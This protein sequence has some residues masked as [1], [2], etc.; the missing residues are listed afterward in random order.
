MRERPE[1]LLAHE[2]RPAPRLARPSKRARDKGSLSGADQVAGGVDLVPHV[3]EQHA[4]RLAV[5]D[6]RDDALAVRL[7][8]VLDDLEP[9]VDE[10]DGLVAEVEEVGVEERQ[11]VVRCA[12]AG[13][14]R[15]DGLAV[16]VRVILVLD[17]QRRPERADGEARDVAGGEDVLVPGHAAVSSTTI[18]SATSSPADSASSVSAITPSPATTASASSV[19]PE[20]VS[21]RLPEAE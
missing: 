5:L 2:L 12:G 17:A 20:S 6:I 8:P 10:P 16:R 15:A 13:H 18:P 7:L 19:R 14:V 21:T 3:P 9:G 1:D 4:A 11:M